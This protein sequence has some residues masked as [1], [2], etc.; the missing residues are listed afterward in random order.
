VVDADQVD[1]S[2]LQRQILHRTED[3]GRAK[4]ESA[5]RA[6]QALNPEVTVVPHRSWLNKD[7]VRDLIV[8]YDLVIDGVDNFPTRYLLNDACVMAGKP[9]VEAGIQRF[10]GMVTTILPGQGPCY[11]CI[12]PDPPAPG[13]IPS[14]Q[15]AGVIGAV[16][17][18][19]GVLQANEAL[20]LIL[21]I[22]QPLVGRLLVFDALDAEFHE[23]AIGRQPDCRL[24][25]EAPTITKL[26]EYSL[27]CSLH[28]QAAGGE[29][30]A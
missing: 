15:E 19:M 6:I 22:G 24:C 17:G 5:A 1:L 27:D 8:G 11:R 18:V 12:F 14:C 4:V 7:N 21:G 28:Q 26:E 20:K 2:N 3:V 23:F 10:G 29:E 30:D 25:G 16:A 13:S 9:L